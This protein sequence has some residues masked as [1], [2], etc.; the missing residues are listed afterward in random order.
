MSLPPTIAVIDDDDPFLDL[1]HDLLTDEGHRVVLGHGLTNALDMLRHALPDMV[2]LDLRL[3]E[4]D[5][6]IGVLRAMRVDAALRDIP[7]L[8][9]TAGVRTVDE[10]AAVIGAL[11]A[12]VLLKP[13]DI[14][15]LLA[16]VMHML[17]AGVEQ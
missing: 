16:R 10:H 8:I 9:C 17:P 12:A 3:G 14:E 7:V 5:A 15:D 1:M 4:V 6:G 13:F 2:I 11:N